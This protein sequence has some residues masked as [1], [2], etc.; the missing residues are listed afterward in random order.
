VEALRKHRA[1][2][3]ELEGKIA[4]LSGIIAH[5]ARPEASPLSPRLLTAEMVLDAIEAPIVQSVN[6]IVS[7]FAERTLSEFREMLTERNAHLY[8]SLW[9]NLSP[10][11]RVLEALEA[12]MVQEDAY[13]HPT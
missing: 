2:Q 9:N 6:S 11:L 1:L 5:I 8:Q 12:Q 3:G 4:V 13:R 10:T 7:S